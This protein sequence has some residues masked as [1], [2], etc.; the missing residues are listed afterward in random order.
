M[1]YEVIPIRQ[2]RESGG[3]LTYSSEE[4]LLPGQIVEIPLGRAKTFGIISKSVKS[5]DFPTKPISR[6]LYDTPLPTHI[7][8]SI[9]WLSGYYLSPLPVVAKMFL[10]SGIGKKRRIKNDLNNLANGTESMPSKADFASV[11]PL[12]PA[13]KTALDSLK[14]T[15][16][17]TSL[18]HGITGSGKTNIYL[19]LAK[20]ALSSG[21]SV[22]LLVPEI[23]LTS[24]LVQIFEQT[25]GK[26]VILLHS[27]QTEATRHLIW[28]NTLNSTS[29]QIIIGPRSALLLPIQHPGLII[30][31]EAHESSYFQENAPRYSALRLGSFIAQTEKIPCIYGTATPLITDYYL[32]KTHQAVVPLMEKAKTTAIAPE[33]HIIDLCNPLNFSKNR[34]FSNQ[35]LENIEKNLSE[36]HQTLIFHNRRGSAN[37]T[38][39]DHCGWQALCPNCYLPLTLHADQYELICHTCGIRQKVPSSCPECKGIGIHHKGFGTKLLE[40]ELK[41]LFPD[42]KIA[43]FD[44]D[45]T[46]N[47]TL[48]A[49]FT[50]V[51]NGDYDI[52]VG[53]Q[54][55]AKG[56]DLP[57]LASVGIVQAD[58]GLSL[59]DYSSEERTFHLLTQVIGRV[60]RGHLDVADVFVQTYQP[61]HPIVQAALKSDYDAFYHHALQSRR[62]GHFPPFY[63]LAKLTVSYKTEATS[64]KYIKNYHK[65]L[66]KYPNLLVS[67]PTPAFHEH[68]STGY[69]WQIT[70]RSTSR[71]NLISVL[72]SLPKNPKM[73]FWIDPPS[74]L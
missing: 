44:A 25:F 40:A 39:C 36:H 10:P 21:K 28:E 52:I 7:V 65:E 27:K 17:S 64:V 31:D 8:K 42:A 45:N 70:I 58:A 43:R 46:K 48:D 73:H 12:N 47:D 54:T 19:Q 26:K 9:F 71:N 59:P 37:L 32:A 13:Q 20:D 67:Q 50:E 56:L 14:N 1:F 34:Y 29:P 61:N 6:A 16:G 62:R 18:L 23:A 41:K 22:I 35:L 60:G 5:V 51:K 66:S 68:T 63:Y 69:T 38:I 3:I 72:N 53:T 11:I 24:Q 33:F 74:L 57:L 49:K 2:F 15:S 30:I 4:K 55:I